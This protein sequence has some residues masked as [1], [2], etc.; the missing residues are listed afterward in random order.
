V[1]APAGASIDPAT[2][3]F[4]WIPDEAQGPG[5]Y[6]FDVCVSDGALSDCETIDVTVSE[7]NIAPVLDPIGDKSINEETL[8]SFTATA[9]DHDIPANTLTFSLVGAPAGATIDQVTGAFS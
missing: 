7:V 2:G 3:E 6:S 4:S 8:L 9:S 5:V 1:D